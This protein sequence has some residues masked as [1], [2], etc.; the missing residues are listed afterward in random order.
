MK[1]FM[2]YAESREMIEQL[3]PEEKAELLDALM[4]YSFGGEMPEISRMANMVFIAIRQKIDAQEESYKN[5]S[6]AGAASAEARRNKAEQNATESNS[7]EQ[8]ATDA[9]R[10]GNININKN[11]NIN[12]NVEEKEEPTAPRKKTTRK[13][14]SFTP[15]TKEEIRDYVHE[16]GLQMDPDAFFDHFESN[17]WKVGGKAPMV[18]WKATARNWA[19]REKTFRPENRK[20]E[21]RIDYDAVIRDLY[22]SGGG[23]TG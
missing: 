15:P 1:A 9:N 14:T 2:I 16:A 3:E 22:I 13:T 19:R 17:G 10:A 5:K 21:R 4:A 20:D 23:A 8:N 12:P 6:K 11:I 18:D 7:G